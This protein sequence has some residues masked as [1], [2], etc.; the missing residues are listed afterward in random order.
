MSF[1]FNDL[2]TFDVANNHQGSLN[3]G[4]RIIEEMGKIASRYHLRAAI[5]LQYR[6]LGTFIH[7]DFRSRRDVKHI[8]R[9]L[10]TKLTWEEFQTLV[11]STKDHG[12][13][14]AVT[15]FDESSVDMA[16]NHGVDILKV[17]SCSATD[18]PL[19]E[20]VSRARKPVIVSTGGCALPEVDRV[21]TFLEHRG[22]TDLALLHCVGLYPTEDR[23]QQLGFMSRLMARYPTCAVGYSGHERPGN[24]GVVR[25][26]IA[27]GAK[28]LE[29]HV[30]LPTAS[31]TLNAYSM[32][33]QEVT[34]WVEEFLATRQLYGS[35]QGNKV[36]SAAEE[37]SLRSLMRG[38]YARHPMQKGQ[39]LTA[40]SVFFAIPCQP[41][42]TPANEYLE[43]MSASKDYASGEAIRERRLQD[44]VQVMR[45]VVHEAKGLL[46]EA[47]ISTGREFDVELSHHYG[48]E[49]F[50]RV[51]ATIVN[52]VNRAYCKKLIIL[53][54]GQFHPS[55]AHMQKEETFQVLHGVME[56][57]LDGVEKSM[58]PG[59]IQLI[60]RGQYHSFRTDAGC[61]F[62]EI[63]TTHIKGDSLYQ[64]PV[65]AALDPVK[66]KTIIE[67]W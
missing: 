35:A 25:A 63:S 44:S 24:L 56:L 6:D 31:I 43:S 17:G 20:K 27:M 33:P 55:H 46:R 66:R 40:D 58:S 50:R 19:L 7:P 59:D 16:L 32:N 15:A 22:V 10:E 39:T 4:L 37:E 18:W 21:V 62:E 30:G 5:K 29:R 54:P 49:S 57:E 1:D 13:L 3:H 64:D 9:F 2:V 11:L 45:R 38:V 34:T 41:G 12:M 67:D 53:L 14:S 8:P 60:E 26:A 36:V 61:V 51:G 52:I 65:I 48:M 28:I 23:D 42:Q 47:R